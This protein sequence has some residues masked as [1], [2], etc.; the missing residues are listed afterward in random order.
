[1]PQPVKLQ[2]NRGLHRRNGSYRACEH[3]RGYAE[4]YSTCSNLHTLILGSK[5]VVGQQRSLRSDGGNLEYDRAGLAAAQQVD[6]PVNVARESDLSQRVSSQ[7]NKFRSGS[8]LSPKRSVGTPMQSSIE[9]YRL[10]SGV[11][12]GDA[13]C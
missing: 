13:R 1:V 6:S 5:P 7:P 3:P 11:F 8:V 4:K 10:Q 9:T 12:F 2:G